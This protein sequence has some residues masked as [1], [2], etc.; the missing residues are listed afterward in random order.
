MSKCLEILKK[1]S[2]K[3]TLLAVGHGCSGF[4]LLQIAA[5]KKSVKDFDTVSL[6]EIAGFIKV[7]F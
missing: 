2:E 6:M 7:K 3:E 4:Y 1:L 5:K